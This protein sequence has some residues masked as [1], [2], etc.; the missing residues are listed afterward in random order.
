MINS[1][2]IVE[3]VDEK[4]LTRFVATRVDCVRRRLNMVVS[5]CVVAIVTEESLLAR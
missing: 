1:W 4:I 3:D 5:G 2:S